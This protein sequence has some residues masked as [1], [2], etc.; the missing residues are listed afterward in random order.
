MHILPNI[1]RGKGNQTLKFG[2]LTEYNMR[3]FF[4]KIYTRNEERRLCPDLFLFVIKALN[5]LK[6]SGQHVTFNIFWKSLTQLYN[7]KNNL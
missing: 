6:A 3:I 2:Q 5:E 1:S 7:N 4:L